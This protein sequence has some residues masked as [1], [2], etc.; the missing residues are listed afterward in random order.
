MDPVSAVGIA[1]AVVSFIEFT[2]SLILTTSKVYRSRDGILPEASSLEQVCKTL[3]ELSTKLQAHGGSALGE[4][5]PSHHQAAHQDVSA[6]VKLSAE[7]KDDCEKLLDSLQE[8][9]TQ[10]GQNRLWGSV[11]V[12]FKSML[13]EKEIERIE[14]RLQRAQKIMTLHLGNILR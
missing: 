7:C 9:Q 13:K 2:G 4:G 10:A 12:A 1:S 5:G 8:L 14:G 6:L 3:H 11:K